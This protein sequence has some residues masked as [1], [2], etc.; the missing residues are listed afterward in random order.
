MDEISPSGSTL[1]WE[2]KNGAVDGWEFEPGSYG[3]ECG[4]LESLAGGEPAENAF[5]IE[6]LLAGEADKVV[7]CAVLLNAA[8][9]LY[10]SA[11]GWSLEEAVERGKES[12][13]NGA[14]AQVLARLR[15]AAPAQKQRE[16]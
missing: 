14:A 2:V 9:A 3:L 13:A 5:R 4:D 1:V 12:L 15:E 6:R 16:R 10:V 7:R 8:A 11:N